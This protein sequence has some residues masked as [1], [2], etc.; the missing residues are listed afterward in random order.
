MWPEL[1]GE[2]GRQLTELSQRIKEQ[3]YDRSQMKPESDIA[4]HVAETHYSFDFKNARILYPCNNVKRR[5]I[6]ESSLICYFTR[7]DIA[8]NLNYDFA[9]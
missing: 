1:I 4:N 8:L 9:R 2:T 6:V 5:Y 7:L 3:K